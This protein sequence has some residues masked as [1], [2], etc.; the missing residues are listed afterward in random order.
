M[1]NQQ[2]TSAQLAWLAGIWDGEGSISFRANMLRKE[3]EKTYPQFSP[4]VTMVNT[5]T[6]ILRE[7]MNILDALDIH[8]YLREKGP[9][10]FEGSKKQCWLIS[11]ETL[12]NCAKLLVAIRPY[13][14]GKSFQADLLMR[15][16]TSRIQRNPNRKGFKKK[17]HSLYDYTREEL[18]SLDNILVANG[19]IHKARGTSEIIRRALEKRQQRDDMIRPASRDAEVG[20]NDLLDLQACK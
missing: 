16:I 4:R 20:R 2:V 9:G 19:M 8:Y 5:N 3:T 13:L 15:F 6:A 14:I 12:S 7:V 17:D 10:G 1:G 11:M 18:E